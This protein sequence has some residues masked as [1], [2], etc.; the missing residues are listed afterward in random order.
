MNSDNKLKLINIIVIYTAV[1]T[2]ILFL[3]LSADYSNDIINFSEGTVIIAQKILIALGLEEVIKFL[4]EIP[5]FTLICASGIFHIVI[6]LFVLKIFKNRVEQGAM[7]MIKKPSKVIALGNFVYLLGIILFF[8][9]AISIIGLPIAFIIGL[10]IHIAVFLGKISLAVF[11]GY[12][13]CQILKVS[14]YTYMYYMI[15]SFFIILCQSVYTIGVAFA[16]YVFP[17][18][19]IGSF[20][21]TIMNRFVFKMSYKVEF[22]TTRQKQKFDRKKIRDIITKG[23]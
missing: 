3:R 20:I 5:V 11:F 2:G 8:V 16:L 13:I 7:I 14:G 22:E 18:L 15:G 9:F 12:N 1:I 6:G 17:V 4:L 21:I 23:L 19:S 10:I